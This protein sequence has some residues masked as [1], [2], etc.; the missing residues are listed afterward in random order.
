ML[1]IYIPLAIISLSMVV[2]SCSEYSISL[3]CGLSYMAYIYT[4]VIASSLYLLFTFFQF[5]VPKIIK[6]SKKIVIKLKEEIKKELK[7]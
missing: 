2:T 1:Y 6:S 4:L 5:I 7:K 3:S